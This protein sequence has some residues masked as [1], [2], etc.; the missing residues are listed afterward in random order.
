[1][2]GD[3]GERR[4]GVLGTLVWDTIRGLPGRTG[5]VE[6]WGGI[7]YALPA[8]EDAL[9]PGWR[10]VPILKVGRDVWPEAQRF[11]VSF[12]SVSDLGAVQVVDE[13]N[14]RV[15]LVYSGTPG[16]RVE[17]LAGGV[18]PWRWSEL[19]GVLGTL[20]A[21]YVNFISGFEMSVD[22]AD[23]LAGSVSG[24]TYADLHS[25]FLG[26]DEQGRRFPRPLPDAPV[27]LGSFDGVQ[28]NE[29]EFRLLAGER[30]DPWQWALGVVEGGDSPT[31]RPERI[32]VTLGPDGAGLVARS[33]DGGARVEKVPTDEPSVEG[34]PT[35]CGDVWGATFFGSF[36]AGTDVI[37]S[38][39]R[40]NRVARLN[41]T[42]QGASQLRSRIAAS[43]RPGGER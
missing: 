15:E 3:G 34:D 16:R 35:G 10:V 41:L 7:A 6:D 2:T 28:V 39:E 24:P 11:L 36:L 30:S 25:L 14:N 27:W 26:L 29:D 40:A 43:G 38:M 13:V 37:P 4:L 12:P 33:P 8:F 32:V 21:L 17:Q 23:R 22:T 5:P 1:M 42:C 9:G 18:P 19:E 31:G 20:D